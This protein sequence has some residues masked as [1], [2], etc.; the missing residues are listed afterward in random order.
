M[1]TE[2]FRNRTKGKRR[3][4]AIC[5]LK[6]PIRNKNKTR[7]NKRAGVIVTSTLAQ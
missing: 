3:G 2:E 7:K 6:V 1:S 4:Y 5:A